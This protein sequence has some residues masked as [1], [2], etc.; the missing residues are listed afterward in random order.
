MVERINRQSRFSVVKKNMFSLSIDDTER[1][2][3]LHTPAT[4]VENRVRAYEPTTA[5][6][7][8]AM[9]AQNYYE[10]KKSRFQADNYHIPRNQPLEG[11]WLIT[12]KFDGIFATWTG[13][14]FLSRQGKELRTPDWFRAPLPNRWL[15]GE[16]WVGEGLFSQT[17]SILRRPFDPTHADCITEPTDISTLAQLAK[18]AKKRP[19]VFWRWMN[20]IVFDLPD[21]PGTYEERL[22]EMKESL[23]GVRWLRIAPAIVYAHRNHLNYVLDDVLQRGGEG[24]MIR[25]AE[26]RYQYG[27]RSPLMLKVK[28]WHEAEALV[29]Q[30]MHGVGRHLT[31]TGKL[32][33]ILPNGTKFTITTGFTDADR[34]RLQ[35]LQKKVVISFFYQGLSEVNHKPR[36]PVFK[37]VRS[38]LHWSAV[39]REQKLKFYQ[40]Y[41]ANNLHNWTSSSATTTLSPQHWSYDVAPSPSPS[42]PVKTTPLTSI[43]EYARQM[44]RDE[45]VLHSWER[46]LPQLTFNGLVYII[47]ALNRRYLSRTTPFYQ[48][49]KST[50]PN[51]CFFLCIESDNYVWDALLRTREKEKE[52][53]TIDCILLDAIQ[54]LANRFFADEPGYDPVGKMRK[55]VCSTFRLPTLRKTVHYF[56]FRNVMCANL[57]LVQKVAERFVAFAKTVLSPFPFFYANASGPEHHVFNLTHAYQGTFP[58][59]FCSFTYRDKAGTDHLLCMPTGME[60]TN[61]Q[62]ANYHSTYLLSPLL[63]PL[64]LVGQ[65]TEWQV[66]RPNTNAI[67]LF[68]SSGQAPPQ[69][70]TSIPPDIVFVS[71]PSVVRAIEAYESCEKTSGFL[72]V[73][74]DEEQKEEQEDV[75][76]P[77]LL[78]EH[79]ELLREERK[80]MTLFHAA[81]NRIVTP[82]F[83]PAIYYRLFLRKP[84]VG[85]NAGAR[86]ERVLP[87]SSSSAIIPSQSFKD[88]LREGRVWENM[89]DAKDYLTDEDNLYDAETEEK[90]E[91]E[92][93]LEFDLTGEEKEEEKVYS[94]PP[95]RSSP[96]KRAAPSLPSA[97]PPPPSSRRH[98]SA[99]K[100]KW[101]EEE[102]EEEEEK[103]LDEFIA[104]WMRRNA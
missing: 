67:R 5:D 88:L 78:F 76:W 63:P 69:V 90:E 46:Q 61:V 25:Q 66:N 60:K 50:T 45:G 43:I 86:L 62:L 28:L 100:L 15:V 89:E 33:C 74:E 1:A 101:E 87:S 84:D 59:P 95:P 71:F 17:L 75:Q 92:E 21:H 38:D 24:L 104:E 4:I 83:S 65:V 51:L 26:S 58:F 44:Q 29:I 47:H 27:R 30:R 6:A 98:I 23:Q 70:V 40:L 20:F 19:S 94:T 54:V 11:K 72:S 57:A 8:N 48:V 31:T 35:S 41:D 39:E 77:L 103:E 102:E 68:A 49:I 56:L 34:K 16:F 7:C 99:R 10:T 91:E 2:A 64:D 81:P 85:S 97:H 80:Q 53:R 32:R 73:A 3:L 9:K 42:H 82:V 79:F 12:E 36:F 96:N 52:D 14:R 37:A 18:V 55:M 93:V 22:G 13:K